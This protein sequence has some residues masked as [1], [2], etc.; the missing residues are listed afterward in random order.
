MR[1]ATVS[2]LLIGLL[3]TV[4][5]AV[6]AR[7]VYD[8][9][10]DR[11]LRQRVLAA[12]STLTAAVPSLQAR[13]SAAAEVAEETDGDDAAFDRTI[14]DTAGED[15]Q[16]AGASVWDVERDARVATTGQ[17]VGLADLPADERASILRQ[18][19]ASDTFTVITR[20]D[21]DPPRLAFLAASDLPLDDRR[22]VVYAEAV[23]PPD[24]T[25]VPRRDDAFADLDYALYLGPSEEDE[26]LVAASTPALP[27]DGRREAIDVPFGDTT[28]HLVMTPRQVLGSEWGQRAWWLLALVGTALTLGAAALTDRLVRR[29]VRAEQLS[30]ENARLY[31]EQRTVAQ[32]L[33]HSML[34][35]VLPTIDGVELAVRYEAGVEG[36]DI[37]GDWYDVMTVG[38][39]RVLVVVGDVSG[40][41][42]E[43]ATVMASLRYAIR[44]FASQGDDPATILTKLGPL[45]SVARDGHF[46]TVLCAVLD[47]PTGEVTIATA[48]HPPPALAEGRDC[49]FVDVPVGVPVGLRAS[50]PYESVTIRLPARGTLLAFTDGLVERRGESLDDGLD[51]LCA[52]VAQHDGDLDG[53]L[54]RLVEALTPD[55]SE[56]DAAI[57][58][59]RWT[60]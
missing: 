26:S 18:G 56:D 38:D 40:R 23:L 12:S 42:L 27:L 33:Q 57:L 24:R 60:R 55:R 17:L 9:D 35:E 5:L 8:R 4:A 31:A 50:G 51:R 10:E 34:P 6:T 54:S 3:I 11:L 20:F 48:G 13:L 52:T 47:A 16:F 7:G 32:T 39:Q 37:G 1:R 41:G 15:A 19:R 49:R 2:V 53:L 58:G 22:Y 59:L 29:R 43:A 36:V 46:A 44:A 14:G 28:L 25:A 21:T 45:V 30:E